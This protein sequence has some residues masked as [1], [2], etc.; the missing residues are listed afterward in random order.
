[1]QITLPN[2]QVIE[3]VEPTQQNVVKIKTNTQLQQEDAEVRRKLSDLP[4]LAN[5]NII[6]Q[7][8][9]YHL[10]GLSTQDISTITKIPLQNVQTI[11]MS[12][13]FAE[14]KSKMLASIKERD[15]SDVREYISKASKKAAEKV[16]DIMQN[17]ANPKF[18]L[19]AAK[20]IL[21]RSGQR[22]VD[23][24]EHKMKID[25]E[26]RILYITKNDNEK[27]QLENIK[28]IDAEYEEINGT[29]NI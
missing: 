15:E 9:C 21:D 25:N 17:C 27:K 4:D 3:K 24:V 5:V 22:P 11:L 18:S 14:Y 20:D 26:L 23:V 12:H 28:P 29:T 1:M 19:E 10:Y 7:V 13:D 8:L 16:V 6:S 2:G